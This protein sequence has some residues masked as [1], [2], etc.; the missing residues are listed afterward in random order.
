M[1][2]PPVLRPR[3]RFDEHSRASDCRPRARGW[4]GSTTASVSL[5]RYSLGWSV[6]CSEVESQG[7]LPQ[8]QLVNAH[9]VLLQNGQI[10]DTTRDAAYVWWLEQGGHQK[11]SVQVLLDEFIA[12]LGGVDAEDLDQNMYTLAVDQP[13]VVHP[14]THR[15][16]QLSSIRSF[17]AEDPR[18][19]STRSSPT[20]SA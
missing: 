18:W 2:R 7:P 1:G 9:A 11:E 5:K 19:I 15:S 10:P 12:Q 6:H 3:A 20:Y 4:F 13:R 16:R 8:D 14:L 17:S